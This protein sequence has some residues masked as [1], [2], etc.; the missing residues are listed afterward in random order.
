MD[1]IKC[2]H[3]FK[4]KWGLNAL[5]CCTKTEEKSGILA[6]KIA[7]FHFNYFTACDF[8]SLYEDT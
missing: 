5:S 8:V 6:S 7:H 1:K 4:V 3:V 2:S